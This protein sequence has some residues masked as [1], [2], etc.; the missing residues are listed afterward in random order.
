VREGIGRG[1]GSPL[2]LLSW[3][4]CKEKGEEKK[5]ERRSKDIWPK[6]V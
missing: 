3:S 6:F 2:G 5:K 1:K 4:V